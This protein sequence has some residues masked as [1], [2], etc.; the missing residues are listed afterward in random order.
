MNSGNVSRYE[1]AFNR[2]R[3]IHIFC[4]SLQENDSDALIHFFSYSHIQSEDI[5]LDKGKNIEKKKID[6]YIIEENE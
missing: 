4:H 2:N 3:P 5:Y 1:N 6:R